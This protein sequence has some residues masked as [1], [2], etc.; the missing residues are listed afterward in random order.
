M[1]NWQREV[2]LPSLTWINHDSSLGEGIL[3][4]EKIKVSFSRNKMRA[5]AIVSNIICHMWPFGVC[6]FSML[7]E[8]SNFLSRILYCW[9]WETTEIPSYSVLSF[10]FCL[11]ILREHVHERRRGRERRERTLSR[12][13]AVSAELDAGLEFLNREIMT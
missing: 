7:S 4:C 5:M 2:G 13:C 11:F 12:L 8:A 9:C 1:S 3:A 10:F 6:W